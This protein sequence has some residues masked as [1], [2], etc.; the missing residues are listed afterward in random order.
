MRFQY[1]MFYGDDTIYDKDRLAKLI[2]WLSDVK[3][4]MADPL[5]KEEKEQQIKEIVQEGQ[6]IESAEGKYNTN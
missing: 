4:I 5:T 1:V 3:E 2:K 6:K